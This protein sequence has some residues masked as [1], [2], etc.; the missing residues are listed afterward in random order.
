MR[1]IYAYLGEAVTAVAQRLDSRSIGKSKTK[2]QNRSYLDERIGAWSVRSCSR[3]PVDDLK[4]F[5]GVKDFFRSESCT[6]L[7]AVGNVQAATGGRCLTNLIRHPLLSVKGSLPH[8]RR[9]ER[10]QGRCL[11]FGRRLWP[12][13]KN[14]VS[15]TGGSSP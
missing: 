3:W 12:L 2:I 10:F 7:R 5:L 1:K 13:N 8:R 4:E 6:F 11:G 14:A 9:T 15:A